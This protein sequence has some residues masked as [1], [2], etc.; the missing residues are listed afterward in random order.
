MQPDRHAVAYVR[1]EVIDDE[2]AGEEQARAE[3]DVEQPAGRDVDHRQEDPEVEER[4]AEVVRLDEDEHRAAPDQ[5]QRP[6]VLQSSLC[7][8]LALLAQ[9][10]GEE[11]DQEHLRELARLELER[12][13][14][15]PEASAV[16]RGAE[17]GHCRQDEQPDRR[18][19][20]EVLVALEPPVVAVERVQR[21]R[22]RGQGNHDPEALA[23]C[24]GG[25][26]PVDLGQADAGQQARH[27]QQIRVGE[28]HGQPRDEVCREIEREE[29]ARVRE[30][31]GGNDVLPRDVDAGE[32]ERGQDADDDQIRELAVPRAHLAPICSS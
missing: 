10:P 3:A 18:Q 28:R 17:P 29:E 16:D 13:D 2:R 23:E 31:R 14:M 22:E 25:V 9:V 5:Q 1:D 12:A 11:H 30:R 19:A 21:D 6:E 20:E 8:H 27:G 4:A 7:Q 32:P 15:H 24:V 26:E